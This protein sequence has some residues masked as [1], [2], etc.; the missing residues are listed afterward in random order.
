MNW[1]SNLDL[2][3]RRTDHALNAVTMAAQSAKSNIQTTLAHAQAMI[4]Q[5]ISD[6]KDFTNEEIDDGKHMVTAA[7]AGIKAPFEE[8]LGNVSAAETARVN[9]AAAR[10]TAELE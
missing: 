3:V 9:A 7:V 2:A 4:K 1:T 8:E 5:N 10:W 6:F